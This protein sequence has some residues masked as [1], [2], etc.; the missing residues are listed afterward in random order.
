MDTIIVS[1]PVILSGSFYGSILSVINGWLLA[2]F[3]QKV[4]NMDFAL[5]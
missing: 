2:A 5:A 3:I 4:Q 1:C